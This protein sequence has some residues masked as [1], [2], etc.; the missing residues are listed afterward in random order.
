MLKGRETD[1]PPDFSAARAT[2]I[3]TGSTHGK[4]IHGSRQ[5]RRRDGGRRSLAETCGAFRFNSLCLT[6]QVLWFL[7]ETLSINLWEGREGL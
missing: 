5:L 6:G 1:A 3:R 7:P 2:A 4:A